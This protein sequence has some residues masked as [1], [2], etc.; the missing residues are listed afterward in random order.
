MYICIQRVIRRVQQ[1]RQKENKLLYIVGSIVLVHSV[2]RNDGLVD[3]FA[4]SSTESKSRAPQ[5]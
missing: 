5:Y 3:Y 1:Y 2:K 4:E